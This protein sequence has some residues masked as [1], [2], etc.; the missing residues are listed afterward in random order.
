MAQSFIINSFLYPWNRAKPKNLLSHC[1]R[2]SLTLFYGTANSLYRAFVHENSQSRYSMSRTVHGVKTRQEMSIY[3][4]HALVDKFESFLHTKHVS[5][6]NFSQHETL[7]CKWPT[8][9]QITTHAHT[10]ITHD[11]SCNP[12]CL[13]LCTNNLSF[14]N[15]PPALIS[16][17]SYF[18]QAKSYSSRVLSFV[19]QIYHA[20]SY[21][22]SNYY[23]VF[24][25]AVGV[26]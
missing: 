10:C 25:D 9:P 24:L 8:Y 7:S 5:N 15:I 26:L 19:Y 20:A 12:A 23:I 4:S 1:C 18:H 22:G 21:Y 2:V 3:K 6:L 13:A 17:S 16:S 11:F 14:S